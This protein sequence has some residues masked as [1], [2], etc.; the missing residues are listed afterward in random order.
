MKILFK[1]NKSERKKKNKNIYKIKELEIDFVK[2]LIC[3]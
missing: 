3:K 1:K 2:L